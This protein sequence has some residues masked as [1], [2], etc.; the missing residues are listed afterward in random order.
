MASPKAIN[1]RY[2]AAS[3]P[4]TRMTSSSLVEK[5]GAIHPRK[6][7]G[8]RLGFGPFPFM[9]LLKVRAQWAL[10][11]LFCECATP[12]SRKHTA[13]AQRWRR[14]AQSLPVWLVAMQ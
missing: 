7:V 3:T 1:R 9:Y 10:C 8:S 11:K 2:I 14:E 12:R 13:I 5:T 4:E 6:L